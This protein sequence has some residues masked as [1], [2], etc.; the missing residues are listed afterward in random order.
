MN[1]L[2]TQKP[3]CHKIFR[4]HQFTREG[5][6][7]SPQTRSKLLVGLNPQAVGCPC[8]C[9]D[10]V[11]RPIASMLLKLLGA[12][13][14]EQFLKHNHHPQLICGNC[15]A[16]IRIWLCVIELSDVSALCKIFS[17]LISSSNTCSSIH[18]SNW[19]EISVNR[20]PPSDHPVLAFRGAPATY[21]IQPQH[22]QL[23]RLLQWSDSIESIATKYINE[24]LQPGKYVGIHLRNEDAWV[25][26]F[27]FLVLFEAMPVK[28]TYRC[29]CW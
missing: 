20:F 29:F 28:K 10:I 18:S 12:T 2:L 24:N 13:S 7:S 22:I 25:I 27:T 17:I 23:Q 21:P 5:I 19:E 15:F 16:M 1:K 3:K 26:A 11:A 9:K 14:E 8:M 6:K 4:I